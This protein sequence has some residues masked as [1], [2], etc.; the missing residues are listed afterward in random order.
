[1]PIC[2]Y[3]PCGDL[4]KKK[5]RI[6]KQGGAKDRYL[7]AVY[8][9]NKIGKSIETHRVVAKHFIENVDPINK[10]NVN[11]INGI[12][13]DNTVGN[14]EWVTPSENS[15]HLF[16]VLKRGFSKKRKIAMI[17]MGGNIIEEFE[18]FASANRKT[19]IS[20]T[21]I[22]DVCN[23]KIKKTHGLFWKYL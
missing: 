9:L 15:L 21:C 7:N 10:T 18:S 1:M 16:R 5:P 11:H 12:K 8:Y 20:Q 17:D 22:W 19:G 13:T 23:G 4:S 3:V 6:L 14:L 2:K